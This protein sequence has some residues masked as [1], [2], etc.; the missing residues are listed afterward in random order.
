MVSTEVERHSGV[1][2]AD[3]PSAD[4][5][6]S[7]INYRTWYLVG[8]GVIGFLLLMLHGNHVGHVEDAYLIVFAALGVAVLV[9]DWW[10]RRRGWLR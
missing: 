5:G 10:L 6:W 4:W 2:T 7:R 1:D 3:V 9:R 8:L